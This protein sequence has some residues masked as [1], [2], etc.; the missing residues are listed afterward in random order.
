MKTS[1]KIS[2]Y[3]ILPGGLLAIAILIFVLT[4]PAGSLESADDANGAV[5]AGESPS[6]RKPD[7]PAESVTPPPPNSRGT[8]PAN[9]IGVAL[10]N[11]YFLCAAES[12]RVRADRPRDAAADGQTGSDQRVRRVE[13]TGRPCWV[14]VGGDFRLAFAGR[15]RQNPISPQETVG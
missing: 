5:F 4:R 14:P 11:R 2:L 12:E 13:W 1:D 9:S 15:G 10:G 3:I 6:A 8:G 7:F